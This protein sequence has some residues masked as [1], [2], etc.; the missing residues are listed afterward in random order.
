MKPLI[1]A[2]CLAG[3]LAGCA[4]DRFAL[5]DPV[6]GAE[7]TRLSYR[8]GEKFTLGGKVYQIKKLGPHESAVQQQLKLA[9]I[10]EF[11]SRQSHPRDLVLF[12]ADSMREWGPTNSPLARKISIDVHVHPERQKDIPLVTMYTVTDISV[13]EL[14]KAIAKHSNGRLGIEGTRVLIEYGK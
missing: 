8:T 12:C 9:I 2:L 10:P 13:Y 14:L 1:I 4:Q 5:I 3:L 6:S 7:V 11:C